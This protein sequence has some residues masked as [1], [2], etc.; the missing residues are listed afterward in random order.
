MNRWGEKRQKRKIKLVG[1][2]VMDRIDMTLLLL[3]DMFRVYIWKKEF[4]HA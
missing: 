2:A 1:T 4:I 3:L